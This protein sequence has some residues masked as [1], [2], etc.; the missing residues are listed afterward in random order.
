MKEREGYN[1]RHP[2]QNQSHMLILFEG[3]RAGGCRIPDPH[4]REHYQEIILF[5][6]MPVCF[7]RWETCQMSDAVLKLY[8]PLVAKDLVYRREIWR[9]NLKI[10]LVVSCIVR[11]N[12]SGKTRGGINAPPRIPQD[13]YVR[14]QTRPQDAQ[15]CQTSASGTPQDIGTTNLCV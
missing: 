10:I 4:E 13:V 8:V 14:Q 6:K 9:R 3:I 11:G 7:Q 15:R 5:H 1:A 2:P 12:V